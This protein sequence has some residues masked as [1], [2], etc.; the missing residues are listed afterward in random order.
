[1]SLKRAAPRGIIVAHC[2]AALRQQ[3]CERRIYA[4]LHAHRC[5]Q[6]TYLLVVSRKIV[7]ESEGIYFVT[8]DIP[9][10]PPSKGPLCCRAVCKSLSLSLVLYIKLYKWREF[11]LARVQLTFWPAVRR[12]G[13]EE[14]F[15][16][17]DYPQTTKPAWMK[18]IRLSVRLK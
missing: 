9:P 6:S 14:L 7:A 3:L 4:R 13:N 12:D 11:R 18:K 10:K 15:S 8:R 16:S 17:R 2:C 1:M 5:S